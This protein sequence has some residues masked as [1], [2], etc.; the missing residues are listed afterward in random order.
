MTRPRPLLLLRLSSL[1]ALGA[2][3]A[4]LIDMY[5]PQPAFC[6]VGSA[7]EKIKL[8]GYGA[9]GGVPVSLIGLCC[10]L[11]LFVLS[12]FSA[13]WA[14]RLTAFGGLGGGVVAVGLVLFQAFEIKAFCKVCI[15]V[16]TSAILAA[17]AA[18]LLLRD[19]DGPREEG[20]PLLSWLG[21]IVAAFGVP[22]GVSQLKPPAT[23]PAPVMALWKPGAVNVIEF[24]DFECPYCRLAHPQLEAAVHKVK[25]PVNFV[26]KSMPLPMHPHARDAS[27]GWACAVAQG[28]GDAMADKLFTQEDLSKEAFAASAEALKLSME[29]FR[30]CIADPA[31]DRAI[32]SDVALIRSAEFQGLPTVWVGDQLLLGA[33]PEAEYEAA[34]ERAQG[35]GSA[36]SNALPLFWAV[37]LSVGLVLFGLR[38][39]ARKPAA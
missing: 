26:R 3:V 10:F 29:P 25:G 23:V 4:G 5:R 39:S 6:T 22:M 24:S 30:A 33:R 12:F 34:L 27:R 36:G 18:G 14:R 20:V 13:G 21:L 11:G 31:T 7:C 8:L 2:S 38:S 32:D 28:K 1:V 17:V 19:I 35:G 16:D 9:V 15:T 37:A